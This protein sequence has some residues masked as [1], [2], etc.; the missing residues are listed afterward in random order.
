MLGAARLLLAALLAGSGLTIAAAPVH[1]A[2]IEVT[3]SALLGGHVR[4]GAWAAVKVHIVNNGPAL[5]GELRV[6]TQQQGLSRY[7]VSVQLAPDAIQDHLLYTQPPLFGSKLVVEL[8]SGETVVSAVDVPIK[9]HDSY[10]PIVAVI[11][12]RPEGVLRDIGDAVRNPNFGTTPSVITLTPADLPPRVEAWSAIDRLVWQDIDFGLLDREQLAALRLWVGAGGRLIVLG[13]T[14]GVG[15]LSELPAEM[16]PYLPE[17]TVDVAT[18]DL[19]ALLGNLPADAVPLPAVAGTLLRGSVLARSGD[20]VYAAQTSYGQGAVTMIGI[21]PGTG[22]LAGT[23]SAGTLW[24]RA[25]PLGQGAFVNPFVIADDQIFQNALY[26]LPAVA[27]PPIEQLFVL[28]FAYIALIGPINYLVLRRLDRREWA[29]VTMP[30]L[31]I[32]FAVGSYGLGAALK[33]SDVIV[34]QVAIVRAGQQTEQGLGQ[35]YVGVFSPSRRSFDVRINGGPLLSSPSSQTNIGQAEQPIDALIGNTISRLRNF[36]VGFGVVRGFRADATTTAPRISANLRLVQGRVTGSVTNESSAVLE[37]VAVVFGGGAMVIAELKPGD[38]AE[39]DIGMASEQFG[40]QL[41]ERIFGSSFPREVEAQRRVITRRAVIDQITGYGNRIQGG[42]ADVPVLLGWRSGPV[43]D[44]ELAGERPNQVGDSL[45]VVPLAM[46]YDA[47]A[48]FEDQ[49]LVKTIVDSNSDQAWNDGGGYYLGRGTMT[50]ELRPA[51]LSGSFR[52]AKLELALTQSGATL[53][54]N[55]RQISPL[56]DAEQPDQED[57]LGDPPAA[58]CFEPPCDDIIGGGGGGDRDEPPGKPAP[59]PFPGGE[60]WQPIPALQL[61]DPAAGRWYEFEQ[62]GDATAYVITD[63]A[64]WV[65]DT[66]RVVIRLVN[67]TGVGEP[68][69]FQLLARLEGTIE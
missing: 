51:G 15:T 31:V 47:Q 68:N 7:G 61:W 1:A 67:R 11:A 28:L 36:E 13:G 35:V 49:L 63:A 54:G 55:G 5:N 19:G 9:S 65:D 42:T 10:S 33:G 64:R 56:P 6:R 34:N 14:T 12:E 29:W 2:D 26:N 53:R 45:Y 57:P 25:L 3:A 50:V 52:A 4:P 40:Y 66:G 37:N 21:N 44:V 38:S 69:Y 62:F 30:L 22:W 58:D 24:R 18:A 59:E 46:T 41:S 17:R 27:L 32:V 48:L 60:G 16:L 8:V 23:D 20:V 39:V 43:L